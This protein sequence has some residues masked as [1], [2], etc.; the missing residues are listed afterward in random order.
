MS[1]FDS[2]NV[3]APLI[4]NG[5]GIT[6]RAEMLSL[7]DMWRAAGSPENREPWNWERFEGAPFVAAVGLAHNLSVAQVMAKRR[8]KNGGTWAHWQVALAYA[9][10]LS[11]EFHIWC[12]TVVRERM[13]GRSVSVATLSPEIVEMIRRDDGI[14]RMLA[15]KV[16][17]LEEAVARIAAVVEPPAPALRRYGRTAGQIWRGHGLPP[18]KSAANWFGNR[19]AEMGCQAGRFDRGPLA[20]RLFDPDKAE[21]VMRN[22][23][24]HRAEQYAAERQGQGRLRLVKGEAA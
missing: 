9:K 1:D 11:P 22:G 16:K 2:R 20:V 6:A 12:N 10:Y 23:L 13:E 8:G 4:Y 19:L 17:G 15:H 18:L 14:S 3:P 21:I 7:T 5:Q 24:K